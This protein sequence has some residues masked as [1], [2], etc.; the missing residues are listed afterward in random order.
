MP[1][2]TWQQLIDLNLTSTFLC[3]KMLGGAMIARGQGGRIIN[4]A[5]ISGAGRQPRHRRAALRDGEGGGAPVHPRVA[6]DWAP[7]GV[8]VNAILPGRLHDR[9][10]PALVRACIRR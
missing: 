3:T 5:S 9:A 6:A 7:H 1:L 4:I 2:E 10:E 8:T